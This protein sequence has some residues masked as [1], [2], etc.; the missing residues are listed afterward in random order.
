V[1]KKKSKKSLLH[2]LG[3][4]FYELD[5]RRELFSLGNRQNVH[6]NINSKGNQNHKDVHEDFST[7]PYENYQ[8]ISEQF[9]SE[10]NAS[11][12][13]H[14]L[15]FQYENGNSQQGYLLFIKGVIKEDSISN[16]II[17]PLTT[18]KIKNSNDFPSFVQNSLLRTLESQIST[19]VDEVVQ[20]MVYGFSALFLP[21]EPC[22]ILINTSYAEGRQVGQ[23]RIELA[24]RGSQEGFVE[25]LDSNLALIQKYIKTNHLIFEPIEYRG[26]NKEKVV[27]VYIEEITNSKLIDEVK[28]R[29]S[30]INFDFFISGGVI[31]QLIED[32]PY[33]FLPTSTMTERPDRSAGMLLDGHVLLFVENTPFALICPTTFWTLFQTSDEVNMRTFYANFIR[34]VRLLA[35]FFALFS[36]G[37]YISLVNYQ[38]EMIP[39]DLVITI[40][41]SREMLPFPSIV[42]V[43]IMEVSFEFI[44]E[45]GIRLP[46]A[47]GSTIGI[48]GA[49]ILGQAAVQANLISPLLVI[50]VSI[51]GLC[52]YVI[53]NQDLSY[54]IRIGRFVFLGLGSLIGFFGIAIGVLFTITHIVTLQSFGVP[55]LSPSY[56]YI[57]SNNDTLLRKHIWK[58]LNYGNSNR[59]KKWKRAMD[60]LR[61]WDQV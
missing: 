38:P 28:T 15:H 17:K 25:S 12:V 61:K 14:P 39:S 44:Y 52:S 43:L 36:P 54:A 7:N 9:H 10:K 55:F 5:E 11:F 19:S 20:K 40:A 57:K 49:L 33:S 13:V 29:V 60:A 48:V 26:I 46:R 18:C 50:L 16:N 37:V 3:I 30:S 34:I 32:E 22:C 31:A 27:M 45:A 51:T 53:P 21:M 56:P 2:R 24:V 35:V 6:G 59:P 4:F 1:K 23:T 42:E 58:E 8:L 47:I 41:G